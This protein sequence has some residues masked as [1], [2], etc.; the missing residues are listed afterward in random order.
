MF[1]R[2]LLPRWGVRSHEQLIGTFSITLGIIA[3]E[4]ALAT[5][6]QQKEIVFL[7]KVVLDNHRAL[8]DILAE[9][10]GVCAV[11]NTSCCTYFNASTK[12][13]THI[14]KIRQ[15]ATWLQQVSPEMPGPDRF[16]G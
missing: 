11:A 15:K 5:A 16:S 9:Q 2:V 10:G 7:D 4:T 12:I 6:A 13:E 1:C 14:G 8:D 3:H